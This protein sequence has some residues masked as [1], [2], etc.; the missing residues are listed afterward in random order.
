MIEGQEGLTWERWRQIMTAAE[1]LGY[2]SLWRSDHFMSLVDGERH[3]LETWA[4][5]TLAAAETKRLRFGP[6]VCPITFRHPSLLARTAAAVDELSGGRLV[7]GLGVGWNER[8]HRAFGLS[9]PPLQ[10]RLDR[11]EEGLQVIRL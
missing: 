11:L 7:L 10:E 9:F 5:L 3:S 4:T 6:L 8:E 1:Q 2:E